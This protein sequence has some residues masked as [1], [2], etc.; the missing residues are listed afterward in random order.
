MYSMSSTSSNAHVDSAVLSTLERAYTK[1]LQL[2][3]KLEIWSNEE[4]QSLRVLMRLH[5][6][7]PEW[8]T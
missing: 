2:L 8:L 1:K 7:S 5:S 6:A 4:L 3:V